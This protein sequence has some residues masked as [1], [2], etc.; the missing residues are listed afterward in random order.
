[1]FEGFE[2]LVQ[3]CLKRCRQPLQSGAALGQDRVI[4]QAALLVFLI[5][6][7]IAFAPFVMAR[8]PSRLGHKQKWSFSDLAADDMAEKIAEAPN[9]AKKTH[10][11]SPVTPAKA[12][13]SSH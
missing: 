8:T 5:I 7:E 2:R 1:M 12:T 11:P 10:S 6:L 4:A 9:N 13:A 3:C